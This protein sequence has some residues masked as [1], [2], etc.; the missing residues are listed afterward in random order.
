LTTKS[1]VNYLVADTKQWEQSAAY[2]LERHRNVRSWVKN[3]GLGFA[4]PYI[5]NGQPHDYLPDF[6]V[7]FE[8]RPD[9]Y[10]ILETKGYDELME[11][12]RAAAERWCRA[13][14]ADGRKGSWRYGLARSPSDVA[15]LL[16]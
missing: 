12:K 2:Q 8:G 9:E 10:L 14:N 13:V 5:H 16:G 6:I 3:A 4:I 15:F 7:T 1:H 11:V